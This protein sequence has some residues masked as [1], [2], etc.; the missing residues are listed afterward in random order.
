MNTYLASAFV[1]REH[2]NG[3]G[4][5]NLVPSGL[6]GKLS[7][8]RRVMKGPDFETLAG[9]GWFTEHWVVFSGR[10]ASGGSCAGWVSC[11]VSHAKLHSFMLPSRSL[12]LK[13]SQELPLTRLSITLLSQISSPECRLH[14]ALNTSDDLYQRWHTADFHPH[15]LSGKREQK[16]GQSS[17]EVQSK[18]GFPGSFWKNQTVLRKE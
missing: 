14:R 1:Q 11:A 3:D 5:I 8:A 12:R 16:W 17:H 9:S 13:S 15:V 7:R 2:A 4:W 6:P 10:Q 18:P